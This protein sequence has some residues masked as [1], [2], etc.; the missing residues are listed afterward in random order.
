MYHMVL[1]P[2][3]KLFN[4]RNE[5]CKELSKKG[6]ETRQG[7]VPFNLQRIFIDKKMTKPNDCPN[8]NA[9]SGSSFYIPTG[10]DISEKELK[11]VASNF[12]EIIDKLIN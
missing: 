10:P 6:I 4:K 8:A 1:K 7:F 2:N 3:E 9:I 11:Y 5:I 12:L